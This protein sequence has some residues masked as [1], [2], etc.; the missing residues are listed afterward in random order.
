LRKRFSFHHLL[1]IYECISGWWF[2]I[3]KILVSWDDYSQFVY[4]YRWIKKNVPNHQ[5]VQYILFFGMTC[6]SHQSW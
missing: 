3:L 5:P 1:V 6:N 2:P 4:I